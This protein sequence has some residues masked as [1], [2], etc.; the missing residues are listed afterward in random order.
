M[1]LYNY[2]LKRSRLFLSIYGF[3]F[4]FILSY[5]QSIRMENEV[6]TIRNH[7]TTSILYVDIP[8]KSSARWQQMLHPSSTLLHLDTTGILWDTSHHTLTII[9][10]KF[11]AKDS[12]SFT[13]IAIFSPVLPE[14][15]S[16][17]EGALLFEN[18]N[19][20]IAKIKTAA[21]TIHYKAIYQENGEYISDSIY[22]IQ[23]GVGRNNRESDY[24]LQRGDKIQKTKVEN[25]Y[26][27]HIG[28]FYSEAAARERLLFY[29]KQVPDAFIVKEKRE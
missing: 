7:I 25:R 22:F 10:E 26:K 24:K 27:Y 20:K 29:K 12:F 21:Q 9:W 17:G 4:T 13:F 23:V 6:D 8:T 1:I 19:N 15:F 5:G 3:L 11:P 2:L 16:W 18:T 14:T 28:P